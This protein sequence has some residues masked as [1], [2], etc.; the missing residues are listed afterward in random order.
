ML[1][2]LT[3]NHTLK[4]EKCSCTFKK[5]PVITFCALDLITS[6]EFRPKVRHASAVFIEFKNTV[7]QNVLVFDNQ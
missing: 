4:P 2:F 1:L 5:K 3:S 7:I 6:R